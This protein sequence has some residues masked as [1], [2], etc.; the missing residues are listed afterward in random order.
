M[1]KGDPHQTIDG[2]PGTFIWLLLGHLIASLGWQ[3]PSEM[4]Q[5]QMRLTTSMP[6]GNKGCAA[7]R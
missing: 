1:M 3:L 6:S 5:P 7:G 2:R 4:E